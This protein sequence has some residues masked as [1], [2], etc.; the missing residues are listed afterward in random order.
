MSTLLPSSGTPFLYLLFAGALLWATSRLLR[1]L[2]LPAAAVLCLLPLVFTGPALVTGRVYAPIDLPYTAE[3][4]KSLADDRGLDVDFRPTRFDLAFRLI[5]WRKAARYALK[6][7]QW[8]TWNPFM[9]SGDVLAA[10]A[11]PAVYHPLHLASYLLPLGP[12]LTFVAAAFFFVAGWSAFCFH[13]E[14][15]CRESAAILGAAGWMFCDFLFFWTGWPLSLTAA[16]FPFL[17]LAVRRVARAPGRRSAGLLTTAFVLVLLAGHPESA[18][19]CVAVAM[20]YGMVELL[21]ARRRSISAAVGWSLASAALAL[22]LCAVYLLPLIEALP[23]THDY[24]MRRGSTA[25]AVESVPWDLALERMRTAVA[26]FAYGVP[27]R[28]LIKTPGFVAQASAYSGSVL[29]PLAVLGLWR[30]RWRGRWLMLVLAAAGLLAFVAAPGLTD[31]LARLP[32]FDIS[33]NRRLIFVTA[34]AVSVLAALGCEA[35]IR[36]SDRRRLGWS[37]LV[38]LVGLA[39]SIAALWP[40]LRGDG[41]SAD[42]LRWRTAL[43]LVPL[44][45]AAALIFT[46]R[47]ARVAVWGVLVILL[48]QRWAQTAELHPTL[49]ESLFFPPI[50]ELRALPRDGAPYR[51]VG[52]GPCLPANISALYELEDVRGVTPMA[53]LRYFDTRG[54][55]SGGRARAVRDLDRP[56]LDFLNVRFAIALPWAPVPAAWKRIAA[57]RGFAVYENS[58]AL[59]R[60]FVPERVRRVESILQLRREMEAAEDFSRT[61]WIEASGPDAALPAG[62]HANGPGRVAVGRRGLELHLEAEMEQPGWVVVSQTAWKGW[63]ATTGGRELPLH[64]ANH[65]FLAFRLPAGRHP[66]DLVYRPR[67]FVLGRTISFL[68]GAVLAIFLGGSALRRQNPTRSATARRGRWRPFAAG[69]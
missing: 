58:K 51:V 50:E 30:G 17:L 19:H 29:L 42:F 62:E 14:I 39:L 38:V 37:G 4:M 15:G 1:P 64:F 3:P 12:S 5:P 33:I 60:A 11:E 48:A 27:W 13:R 36:D 56:F 34:F 61:V 52:L 18:V 45:L 68:T 24:R 9:L 25:T 67:S 35:W 69:C 53:N 41:L 23:Q 32:L 54:L 55:W 16:F 28:E 10:A 46:V 40:G 49:P 47:S 26:P 20:L 31:L 66:V 7:G 44:A 59:E 6:N 65:A 2:S 43:E 8:P 22:L 57:G 63:R 21:A